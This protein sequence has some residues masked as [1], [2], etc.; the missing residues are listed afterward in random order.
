MHSVGPGLVAGRLDNAPGR[1]AADRNRLPRVLVGVVA[2]FD[3]RVE[4]VHVDVDYATSPFGLFA[5]GA[6][7]RARFLHLM[8]VLR[9]AHGTYYW[10][11]I[12]GGG[13]VLWETEATK[14]PRSN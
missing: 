7:F 4:R 12:V 2:L 6:A 11:W 5:T 10:R 1:V 3:L 9:P 8:G 14:K 13:R